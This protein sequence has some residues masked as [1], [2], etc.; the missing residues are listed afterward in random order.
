MGKFRVGD[1]RS[2]QKAFLT[3][4]SAPDNGIVLYLLDLPV[5]FR[6]PL[7]LLLTAGGRNEF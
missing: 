3:A 5:V 1:N 4:L 2:E 6:L 7:V